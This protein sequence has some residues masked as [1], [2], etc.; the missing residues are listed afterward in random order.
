MQLGA[1]ARRRWFGGLVLVSAIS[2]LVCGEAVLQRRLSPRFFVLYW[3]V[4]FVLTG[5]AF[6]VALRDLRAVQERTRQQH[7]DLLEST[8]NEIETEALRRQRGS[9]AKRLL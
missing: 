6:I 5:I 8:L 9:D 7:R 4:C 1:T 2:M 3:L